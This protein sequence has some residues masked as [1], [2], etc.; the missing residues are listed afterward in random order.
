MAPAAYAT[1][2]LRCTG[3]VTQRA[4]VAS[5]AYLGGVLGYGRRGV[6]RVEEVD[7]GLIT[8]LLSC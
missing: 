8:G 7:D 3:P 5:A 6:E 2:A 4:G 1:R